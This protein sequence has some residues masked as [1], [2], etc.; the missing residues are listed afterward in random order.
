MA[1]RIGRNDRQF[2][3][4]RKRV[5]KGATVCSIC[6]GELDF[7]APPRTSYA[8][9]VDHIIPLSQT[10]HLDPQTRRRMAADP[11]N[12]RPAHFGCNSRRGDARRPAPR[13]ASRR[14]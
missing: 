5:L 2:L 8:P 4:A 12:L 1:Q 3:A 11:T 7:D 14:W 9:S 6:G 13:K 10:R